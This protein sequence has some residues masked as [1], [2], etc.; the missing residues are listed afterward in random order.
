MVIVDTS[1]WIEA[2]RRNGNIRTRL[3]LEALLEND[4]VLLCGPVYLELMGGTRKPERKHLRNLLS[5]LPFQQST[6]S[7]WN[8]A[9]KLSW[10]IRDAGYTLP[11]MDIMIASIALDGR[12]WVFSLDKHFETLSTFLP[13]HLYSPGYNGAFNPNY[14]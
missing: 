4:R 2:F 8:D 12:G 9:T 3:A 5:D 10:Q 7:I 6:H 14:S 13:I 11:W 1:V